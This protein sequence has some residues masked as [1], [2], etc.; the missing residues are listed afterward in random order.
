MGSIFNETAR[1]YEGTVDT[2]ASGEEG[3]KSA[4]NATIIEGALFQIENFAHLVATSHCFTVH[5]RLLWLLN[6]WD[7]SM[8]LK[9]N[10]AYSMDQLQIAHDYHA[11]ASSQSLSTSQRQPL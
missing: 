9:T 10:A 2:V 1:L 6:Q 5:G 11:Q 8:Y 4:V 3:L 7:P